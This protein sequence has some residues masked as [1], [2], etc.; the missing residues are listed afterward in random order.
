MILKRLKQENFELKKKLGAQGLV[1]QV[2]QPFEMMLTNLNESF[3]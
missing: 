1:T 2:N 3:R